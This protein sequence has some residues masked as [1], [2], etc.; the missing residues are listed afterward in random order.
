MTAVIIKL[1]EE[2][3]PPAK[4]IASCTEP[5]TVTDPV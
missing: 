2:Y 5:G 1:P 4:E 3:W